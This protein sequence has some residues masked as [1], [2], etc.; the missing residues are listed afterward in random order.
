MDQMKKSCL[1]R[2]SRQ[3]KHIYTGLNKQIFRNCR[4]RQ[5][6]KIK[7]FELGQ[8]NNFLNISVETVKK[9]ETYRTLVEKTKQS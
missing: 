8:N 1:T 2:H 9:F 4:S 6:K 5:F 7:T 3:L